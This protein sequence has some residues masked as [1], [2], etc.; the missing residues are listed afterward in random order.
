MT[1]EAWVGASFTSP[2]GAFPTAHLLLPD[3][4]DY[5]RE[6]QVDSEHGRASDEQLV[7]AENEISHGRLT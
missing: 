6:D 4:V 1:D 2:W 5:N 7:C 3:N